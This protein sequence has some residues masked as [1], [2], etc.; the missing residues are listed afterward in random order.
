M[1]PAM[2][3][4]SSN[5]IQTQSEGHPPPASHISSYSPLQSQY[6]DSSMVSKIKIAKGKKKCRFMF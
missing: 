6:Y 2:V 1:F 5:A 4:G 3:M